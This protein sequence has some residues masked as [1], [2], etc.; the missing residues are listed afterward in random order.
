[1]EKHTYMTWIVLTFLP[2]ALVAI[3]LH[4]KTESRF[5]AHSSRHSQEQ[6]DHGQRTIYL[7]LNFFDTSKLKK[8]NL[9]LLT[10]L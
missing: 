10:F 8:K 4:S 3:H 9:L 5:S 2:F 1:M 6:K 7:V